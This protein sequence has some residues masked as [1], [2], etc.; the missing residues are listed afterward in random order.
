M[1]LRD[2]QTSQK[3]HFSHVLTNKQG[4]GRGISIA[5]IILFTI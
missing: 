2:H 1:P 4:V 5:F 3:F